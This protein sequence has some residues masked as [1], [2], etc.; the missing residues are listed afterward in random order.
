MESGNAA[1]KSLR[2][3]VEEGNEDCGERADSDRAWPASIGV[4]ECIDAPTLSIVSARCTL[5]LAMRGFVRDALVNGE[6]DDPL[7]APDG[8]NIG[9]SRRAED[10]RDAVDREG[11]ALK[12]ERPLMGYSYCKS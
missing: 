5:F 1:N 7:H 12:R 6:E 11:D 4:I 8:I 2:T 3:L 9:S 10:D